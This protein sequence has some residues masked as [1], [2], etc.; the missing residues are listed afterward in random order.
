MLT[1]AVAAA[2]LAGCD[3]IVMAGSDLA[4]TG[5][6][7]YARGTTYEFDWAWAAAFGTAVLSVFVASPAA[8]GVPRFE[9]RNPA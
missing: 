6:R 7:P 2:C 9:M 1:G 3:P 4:F 8:V 5:G